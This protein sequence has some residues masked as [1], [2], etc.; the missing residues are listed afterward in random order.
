MAIP[1]QD[2]TV[3]DPGLGVVIPAPKMPLITGTASL[4]TNNELVSLS[5]KSAVVTEFG[6]GPLSECACKT[7][8]LAGGPVLCAKLN[9]T[10]AAA[11]GAVT[12]TRTSTST[13]TVAASVTLQDASQVWMIDDP[14]G[15]PAYTDETADFASAAAGDVAPFP[16]VEL[17]GDQ[18]AIGFV[19]PFN[20]VSI[21]IGTAGT[22]GTVNWQYWNGTAWTTV[23]GLS[24]LTVGFQA[25]P[26]TYVLSFTMPTDW[27]PRS[28]STPDELY[29]L[30]ATVV[31]AYTINPLLTQGWIN[32]YGPHDGYEVQVE[33]LTTG[34][35][36]AGTFRYSLDDGRGWSGEHVIPAGGTFNLPSTGVTL[37]FTAGAGPI[38]FEDGDTFAFDCTAPLYTTTDVSNLGTAL[39]AQEVEFPFIVLTGT[40]A[41]AADAATMFATLD[42]EATSFANVNR[43]VRWIM[44]AGNDTVANV[45]AAAPAVTSR[46]IIMCYGT[47]DVSSS[48]P[49]YGWSAPARRLVEMTG[50][51]AAANLISTDLARVASGSLPGVLAVS[52]DE[53]LNEQLDAYQITTTRSHIGRS[54]YYITNCWIK[55]PPGSDYRYLQHGRIMDVMCREIFIQQQL[56]LSAGIRTL[57][58][59][60]A[61][62][63]GRVAGSIDERDA[64][65][66]ED[67]VLKALR[68]QLTQPNNAEGT[69]GHIS[70]DPVY[71]IDRTNSIVTTEQLLSTGSCTPLGYA[72]EITSTIGYDI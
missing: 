67:T 37:T 4:G 68:A 8:D 66:Y 50:A 42:T 62:A 24:D 39:R 34:T 28:L 54:G 55:S 47:T 9:S 13:G 21:I 41:S 16:A 65:R 26:G 69:Q 51:Y 5:S 31:G 57:S 46:R 71:T 35:L 25:A 63:Q 36:G 44:D 15:T 48:K 70:G 27:A 19:Q 60:Q 6:Q 3:N 30:V 49:Q 7:L 20:N 12:T 59:A 32:N 72:K 58:A 23:A 1:N 56:F 17:S 18:F 11:I 14:A 33:V 29:Y 43:F 22:V 52:H 2:I 53:Q 45:Q 64:L 40:H 10:T 61:T 38:F